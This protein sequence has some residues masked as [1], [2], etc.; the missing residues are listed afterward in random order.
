MDEKNKEVRELLLKTR[1]NLI[2]EIKNKARSESDDTVKNEVGDIYDLASNE[3]DRELNLLISDRE[4][5][6]LLQIEDAIKRIDEGSYGTCEECE[7]PIPKERLLIMPF[8]H[9]C[10]SCQAE[11]EKNLT[12]EKEFKEEREYRK[13]AFT[14]SDEEEA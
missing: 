14:S 7:S 6:K 10:V 2:K 8:A 4:R 13:L 5:G 12:I 9:L 11:M 1:E 3:R